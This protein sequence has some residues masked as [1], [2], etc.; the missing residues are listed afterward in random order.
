M[1]VLKFLLILLCAISP[2]LTSCTK[3]KKIVEKVDKTAVLYE[4]TMAELTDSLCNEI[5]AT[6]INNEIKQKIDFSEC[7]IR[8]KKYPDVV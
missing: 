5:V 2:L 7:V 1:K 3:K 8:L 6:S 4:Q